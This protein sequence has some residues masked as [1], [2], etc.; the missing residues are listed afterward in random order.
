M[1]FCSFN[2]LMTNTSGNPTKDQIT[3]YVNENFAKEN[4]LIDW[5]PSDW[6]ENPAFLKRVEDPNF[7]EWAKELND[8]WKILAKK[9]SPNVT[10]HPDR[11]SL[12]T[13]PNGFIVPGGRFQGQR[14][15]SL[16]YNSEFVLLASNS[17]PAVMLSRK[18]FNF[19]LKTIALQGFLLTDEVRK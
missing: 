5:S 10:L 9:I 3:R 16:T 6:Q 19:R 7:R 17:L 15:Q 18:I 4:E 12:I 11:H 13:V 2:K 14:N 8:I 1:L